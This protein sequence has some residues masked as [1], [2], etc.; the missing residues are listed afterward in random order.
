MNKK[1]DQLKASVT[2]FNWKR[3]DAMSLFHM[4]VI[5]FFIAVTIYIIIKF[6]SAIMIYLL[7]VVFMLMVIM[8]IYVIIKKIAQW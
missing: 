2:S 7:W 3:A 5:A 4:S 6:A 8:G 1:L